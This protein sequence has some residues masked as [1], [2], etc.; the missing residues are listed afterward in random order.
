MAER[1]GVSVAT[2]FD[3]FKG[4][5]KLVTDR[6]ASYEAFAKEAKQE[7]TR[8]LSKDHKAET[9]ENVQY[10]NNLAGRFNVSRQWCVSHYLYYRF[11]FAPSL[12]LLFP[13]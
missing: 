10:I 9:G 4:S 8:F 11:I 2:A 13:W 1:L 3:K 5:Q 7:H 6:Y 12:I